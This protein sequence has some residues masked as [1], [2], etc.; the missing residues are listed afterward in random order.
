MAA[1]GCTRHNMDHIQSPLCSGIQGSTRRTCQLLVTSVRGK[2]GNSPRCGLGHINRNGARHDHRSGTFGHC[3]HHRQEYIQGFNKKIADQSSKI[4]TP[5][6]KLLAA[7]D[8]AAKLNNE[9]ASIKSSNGHIG[10]GRGGR[11]D[12]QSNSLPRRPLD[13][14]G[15]CWTHG[16]GVSCDHTRKSCTNNKPVHKDEATRT[17]TMGGL[18]WNDHH[19]FEWHRPGNQAGYINLIH[20]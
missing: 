8:A 7:T 1:Q 17:N 18:S 16:F 13:P 10:R 20:N 9:L 3:H 11:G 2:R 4:T 15:Y 5:T 14:N 12:N 6:K 19:K